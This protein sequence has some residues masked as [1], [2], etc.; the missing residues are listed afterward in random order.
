MRPQ[1]T[2]SPPHPK[3]GELGCGLPRPYLSASGASWGVLD[4]LGLG[5]PTSLLPSP[6]QQSLGRE[7]LFVLL[8][9]WRGVVRWSLPQTPH[10]PR[11]GR[12]GAGPRFLG[13]WR[14]LIASPAPHPHP[15]R[16]PLPT[17]RRR[18]VDPTCSPGSSQPRGPEPGAGCRGPAGSGR[19]SRPRL[20]QSAPAWARLLPAPGASPAG[21]LQTQSE[22]VSGRESARARELGWSPA[23]PPPASP[24]SA[25]HLTCPARPLRA[26]SGPSARAG[27]GARSGRRPGPPPPPPAGAAPPRRPAPRSSRAPSLRAA[28]AGRPPR[29]L[30]SP[31]H[32]TLGAARLGLLRLCSSFSVLPRR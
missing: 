21:S 5:D 22:P 1:Q 23:Q 16:P 9:E 11:V 10:F 29:A 12:E 17:P 6:A 7:V 14:A 8:G 3:R 28:P 18:A 27:H 26:G 19:R 30:A 24:G 20:E 31:G 32:R 15:G 25:G 2:E 4:R 13:G